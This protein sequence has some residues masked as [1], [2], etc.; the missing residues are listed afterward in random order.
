MEKVYVFLADGFEEIEGLT[1]VDILPRAGIETA[2]VSISGKQDVTGSHGICVKTDLLFDRAALEDAGLRLDL[3]APSPEYPS[4]TA[5]LAAYI[6][7]VNG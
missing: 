7:K 5:A 4:I 1:V 2:M 3:E 6:K